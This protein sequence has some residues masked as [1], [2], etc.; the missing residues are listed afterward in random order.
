MCVNKSTQAGPLYGPKVS[1]EILANRSYMTLKMCL[2]H[3]SSR[4]HSIHASGHMTVT[5]FFYMMGRQ[6]F[7]RSC[8]KAYQLPVTKGRISSEQLKDMGKDIL[9]TDQA[10]G[11]PY[12]ASLHPGPLIYTVNLAEGHTVSLLAHRLQFLCQWNEDGVDDKVEGISTHLHIASGQQKHH[13]CLVKYIAKYF[14]SK[15]LYVSESVF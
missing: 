14:R 12:V 9:H 5:M 1:G 13:I 15:K 10:A 3:Y 8:W 7:W 11:I 2:T 4:K 6:P